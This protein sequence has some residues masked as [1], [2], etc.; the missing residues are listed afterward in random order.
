MAEETLRSEVG[1]MTA[2]RAARLS[3][4]RFDL[5]VLLNI[6]TDAFNRPVPDGP[7]GFDIP[8]CLKHA[9]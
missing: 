9:Q 7:T 2:Y 1:V 5:P 8:P 3:F 6:G 4:K